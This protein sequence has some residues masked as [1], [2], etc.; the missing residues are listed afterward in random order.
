[1]TE[2]ILAAISVALALGCLGLA[3]AWKREH[4]AAAYWQT[5][6]AQDVGSPDYFQGLSR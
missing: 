3:V 5:I 2:K 1:M 4:D 6:A